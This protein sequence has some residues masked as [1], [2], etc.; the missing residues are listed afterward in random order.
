MTML[1][2]PRVYLMVAVAALLLAVVAVLVAFFAVPAQREKDVALLTYDV[3]GK[4]SHQ[5]YGSPLPELPQP[6]PV[7]FLRIVDSVDATY[8]YRFQADTPVEWVESQVEVRA[9]VGSPGLWEKEVVLVPPTAQGG[10]FTLAFPLDTPGLLEMGRAIAQELG[11]GPPASEVTLKALVHVVAK[12]AKGQV[13]EDFVQTARVA[14]GSTTLELVR[15]FSETRRGYW[16]G[17]AYRQSGA[18][19]YAVRTRP[20]LLYGSATTADEALRLADSSVPG[21]GAT[22]QS[23]PVYFLR[24]VDSV[25]ATYTYRFQ[26][27]TPVERVESQVEVR[28]VVG[29]PGLWEKEVV[30]A[31]PTTQGAEFTLAFPL[32]IPGLLLQGR[33]IAEELGVGPPAPEIT[34]KALVHVVARTAKGQVE[35]DFVQTAKANVGAAVLE[36]VRPLSQHREGGSPSFRY[37]HDGRFSYSIRLKENLL[38][39]MT[40]MA[41]DPEP[42]EPPW[43]AHT[44][45]RQ[46]ALAPVL[47][48]DADSTLQPQALQ[49]S[50]TYPLAGLDRIDL[51]FA[52]QMKANRPVTDVAHTVEVTGVLSSQEEVATFTLAPRTSKDANFSTT[53]P[54]DIGLYYAA[55]EAA[56]RQR[57]G[58][59][60]S[61]YTFRVRAEVATQGRSAYGPVSQR[62]TQELVVKL[63]KDNVVVPDARPSV[64]PGSI[65]GKAPAPNP[66][67]ALAR[68]G[69]LGLLGLAV[70]GLLGAV[71]GVRMVRMRRVSP[72]EVEVRRIRR[73]HR[74]IF[75]DVEALPPVRPDEKVVWMHSVEELVKAADALL[76]PVLHEAGPERH[77]YCVS[78]GAT[79]YLY[80]SGAKGPPAQP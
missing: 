35:E 25:E 51:T 50:G 10:D 19:G 37:Q 33:A 11:I 43:W 78:D 38:F 52:Y 41:P 9:S 40:T 27:D 66:R 68:M 8:A 30:L 74:D 18:F 34:L 6:N 80:V 22:P 62:F 72:A 39:G 60:P 65:G 73:K 71:V 44:D 13:E 14:G 20:S 17:V 3:E 63:E 1:A 23:N 7:Y 15:P 29:S 67:A 2:L 26:A 21:E 32:D 55:I 70:A 42:D 47:H 59:S 53:F 75:V 12:T 5:T 56:E 46:S 48:P 79:R 16:Q 76:K 24:I 4:I 58:S 77:T 54:L 69:S 28:A 57:P 31:S 61:V 45:Q 64:K 36:L 49:A